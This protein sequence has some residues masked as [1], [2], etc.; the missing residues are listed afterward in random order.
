MVEPR[1]DR[2]RYPAATQIPQ[3]C[4]LRAYELTDGCYTDCY[5]ID[6]DG[7]PDF[8]RYIRLFFDTWIF[9]LERRI[10]A[11]SGQKFATTEDVEALACGEIDRFAAWRVEKRTANELLMTAQKGRIRTWLYLPA[12]RNDLDKTR[13]MFGSAVLP[14]ET[15]DASKKRL[16]WVIRFLLPFHRFYSRLLLKAAARDWSRHRT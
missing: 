4:L 7:P 16:G 13:L 2:M 6:V 10:L 9:R 3:E 14:V 8:Q 11:L 1:L 5:Q 15:G 12:D